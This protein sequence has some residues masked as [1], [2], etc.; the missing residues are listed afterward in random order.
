M[1]T[2]NSCRKEVGNPGQRFFE[3]LGFQTNAAKAKVVV[4]PL[5]YM[6]GK[7]S[8]RAYSCFMMREGESHRE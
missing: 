2:T 8:K 6:W 1:Q 7:D 5:I 4:C 3:W